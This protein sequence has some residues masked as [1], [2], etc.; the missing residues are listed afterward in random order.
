MSEILKVKKLVV[1][2]LDKKNNEQILKN[3]DYSLDKSSSIAIIGESGSGKSVSVKAIAG[4]LNKGLKITNGEI[5]LRGEDINKFPP[6]KRRA[7]LENEFGFVFQDPMSSLNPLYKIEHQIAETFAKN[8]NMSESERKKRVYEL[9]NLVKIKDV[10]TV[11]K[12]YPHQLSGGQRQRIMIAIAIANNPSILIADEPTTALD[13]TVQKRIVLLMKSLVK[14]NDMSMIFISHDLG[15]VKFVT[16]YIY[17]MYEGYILE[18][19]YTSDI[20]ES[21]KH[22]Y[23]IGLINCI[24]DNVKRGDKIPTIYKPK[25]EEIIEK[26]GELFHIRNDIHDYRVLDEISKL[27]EIEKGHFVRV[28]R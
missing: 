5:L 1:E 7:L 3:I 16:D 2:S 10:E 6:K 19:G 15:L 27:V 25:V 13:V 28:Y 4:L 21:P 17:I 24:P 23:T 14:D 8:K 26:S 11:A 12:K 20:F 9:L 22:P 18:S